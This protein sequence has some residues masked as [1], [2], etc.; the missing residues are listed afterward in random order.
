MENIAHCSTCGK[1]YAETK[2]VIVEEDDGKTVLHA[3]CSECKST[4]LIFMAATQFGVVSV[5]MT[6]DLARNEVQT[7]FRGGAVSDDQ[8]IEVY[9]FLKDFRGGVKDI[10]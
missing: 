9:E 3:T 10:I 2:P 7:L 5:G 4:T 8:V 1:K 6:T